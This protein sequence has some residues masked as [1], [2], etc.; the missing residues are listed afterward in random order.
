MI[1]VLHFKD[2]SSTNDYCLDLALG[3]P[4]ISDTA[5]L[6]DTQT[7]GRGR[8][9]TRVWHSV[10][11]N[12]HGSF[13]VNLEK[14]GANKADIQFISCKAAM[15]VKSLLTSLTASSK[16]SL[17]LPNDILVGCKK[18]GGVLTEIAYPF[19]V[20]GIGIN[21]VNSP[22]ETSTDLQKEFGIVARPADLVQDLYKILINALQEA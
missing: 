13:I 11:G 16:F 4:T 14:I 21:L 20:I 22:I 1:K 10:I 9:N 17:K 12:F 19:A 6:A 8:L 3:T 5:V 15:S 2:I 7:A 18:I